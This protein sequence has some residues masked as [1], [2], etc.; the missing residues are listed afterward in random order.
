MTS[1]N[2]STAASRTRPSDKR[3]AIL[4]AARKVFGR[5]G[6]ARAG[7]DV[8]AAEAGAST[9]TLYN[10]FD[11]KEALFTE[12]VTASASEVAEAQ[13]AMLDRHLAAE[14]DLEA[15]LVGLGFDLVTSSVRD[16][17]ADHFAIVRQISV[18]AAHFPAAS[19][20]AWQ[21]AGPR[22]VHRAV[23][24]GFERLQA[25]G[26]LRVA[27]PERTA[28]HYLALINAEVADRTAVDGTPP[29]DADLRAGVAD[30]VHAFLVG[31]LPRA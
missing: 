7:I 19:L 4:H 27:Q 6:F 1:A 5:D 13:I 15:A 2:T 30:G 3:T 23:A 21:E 16:E 29:A 28:R 22:R 31:Y 24:A 17:F 8:I 18:E 25:E 12:T 20:R 11:G 14:T 9:R 10:H 26:R